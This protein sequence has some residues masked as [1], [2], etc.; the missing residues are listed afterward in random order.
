M[1]G[2]EVL[3]PPPRMNR[4]HLLERDRSKVFLRHLGGQ[5]A[6]DF[7]ELR[8]GGSIAMCLRVKQSSQNCL[9]QSRRRMAVLPCAKLL[10]SLHAARVSSSSHDCLDQRA[11]KPLVPKD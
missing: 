11:V 9:G 7:G 4:K 2:V 1:S 10:G 6:L 3:D 5:A 8:I